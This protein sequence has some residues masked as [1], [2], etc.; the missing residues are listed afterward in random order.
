[1]PFFFTK[2]AS[3]T[4]GR[5][6][7]PIGSGSLKLFGRFRV[8]HQAP[9]QVAQAKM[10]VGLVRIGQRCAELEETSESPG[11]SSTKCGFLGTN[12]LFDSQ[13]ASGGD[14][15]PWSR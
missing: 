14:T 1:M 9:Q 11:Y 5:K 4:A 15:I 13:I 2:Q 8:F 10:H 6:C 7:C 3:S 12:V